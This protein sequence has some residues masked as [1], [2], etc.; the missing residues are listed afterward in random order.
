MLEYLGGVCVDCGSVSDLQIDHKDPSQK[1]FNISEAYSYSQE[2]LIPELNKCCLRCR[3]CHQRKTAEADGLEA[4]HGT[5]GMYRHHGCRCEL[6]K[7]ANRQYQRDYQARR[8][9]ES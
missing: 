9:A 8:R 2:V 4:R 5:G 7:A 6:C 1:T 3:I